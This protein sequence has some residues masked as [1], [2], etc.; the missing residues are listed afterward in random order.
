MLRL[1][2][3]LLNRGIFGVVATRADGS[4]TNGEL[5]DVLAS[6]KY[7][8]SGGAACVYSKNFVP[9]LQLTLNSSIA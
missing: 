8:F 1:L 4:V 2:K 6:N 7:D 9:G 3:K 5:R